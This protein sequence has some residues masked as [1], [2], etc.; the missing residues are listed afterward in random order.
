MVASLGNS[1]FIF[2]CSLLFFTCHLHVQEALASFTVLW[3]ETLLSPCFLLCF[4]SRPPIWITPLVQSPVVTIIFFSP[5]RLW[6]LV[7]I[8]R[9]GR[10][11]YM[12]N[13]V[14]FTLHGGCS[15]RKSWSPITVEGLRSVWCTRL[16]ASF[17]KHEQLFQFPFVPELHWGEEWGVHEPFS[18]YCIRPTTLGR[19]CIVKTIIVGIEF[20][21]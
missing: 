21:M 8:L 15:T 20:C 12:C 13:D 9:S 11:S 5:L 4:S 1:M 18:P 19:T 10:A 7:I 17:G 6:P 16:L 3:L 14:Q 2:Y